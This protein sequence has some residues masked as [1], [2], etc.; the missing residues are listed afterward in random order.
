MGKIGLKWEILDC[1][2]KDCTEMGKIVLRKKLI[3]NDQISKSN[4]PRRNFLSLF[5]GVSAWG[6]IVFAFTVSDFA[7]LFKMKSVQK[8]ISRLG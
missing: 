2:V 3:V 1:D 8:R 4:G 7:R 6:S 5:E